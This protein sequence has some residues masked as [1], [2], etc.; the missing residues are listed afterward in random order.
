LSH[1]RKEGGWGAL[2]KISKHISLS[3]HFR[4]NIFANFETIEKIKQNVSE[5]T[6]SSH[7]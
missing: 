5:I 2:S 6:I 4:Y 7:F 1:G 3:T